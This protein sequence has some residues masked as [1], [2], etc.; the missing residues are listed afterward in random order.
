MFVVAFLRQP[1][2]PDTRKHSISLNLFSFPRLQCAYWEGHCATLLL[3]GSSVWRDSP[4]V[5]RPC[6]FYLVYLLEAALTD[7]PGAVSC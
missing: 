6:R 7:A 5:E 2:G 1:S 4:G 3:P